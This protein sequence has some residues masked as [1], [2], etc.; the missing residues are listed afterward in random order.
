MARVVSGIMGGSYE[1][2]SASRVTEALPMRR[3]DPII[4][5]ALDI[6]TS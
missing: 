2:R 1:V 3:Q 5:D 6:E 4:S